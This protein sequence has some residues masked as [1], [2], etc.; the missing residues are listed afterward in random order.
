MKYKIQYTNDDFYE[1]QKV[2]AEKIKSSPRS[3]FIDLVVNFFLWI[4]IALLILTVFSMFI[5]NPHLKGG[6]AYIGGY[7]AAI[8]II[9]FARASYS[10][11]SANMNLLNPNGIFLI[12]K[13]LE[14]YDD[15]LVFSSSYGEQSYNYGSINGYIK[16]E[17]NHYLFVD[18]IEAIIVPV[19]LVSSDFFLDKIHRQS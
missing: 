11:K 1:Y 4:F 17:R 12:A 19:D 2:V 7:I 9:I 16:K 15:R 10:R 5:D 13:D 6:F 18:N 8:L 14:I 3:N